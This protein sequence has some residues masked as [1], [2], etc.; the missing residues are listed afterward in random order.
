M[1]VVTGHLLL[2]ASA[3]KVHSITVTRSATIPYRHRENADQDT[4]GYT[5]SAALA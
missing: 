1:N 2:W 5:I 3:V 4:Y